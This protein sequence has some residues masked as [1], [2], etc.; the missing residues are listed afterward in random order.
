MSFVPGCFPI[1][2]SGLQLTER[3]QKLWPFFWG[4]AKLQAR[5]YVTVNLTSSGISLSK[6]SVWTSLC[7]LPLGH[8]RISFFVP[9]PILRTQLL[10]FYYFVSLLHGLSVPHLDLPEHSKPSFLLLLGKHLQRNIIAESLNK[11]VV[12]QIIRRYISCSFLTL[13]ILTDHPN[14]N[15][16]EV[17]FFQ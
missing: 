7:N 4:M 6:H 16:F 17:E 14:D 9:K 15:L 3:N 10:W 1:L 12:F 11:V 13:L 2:H 5:Q 8:V